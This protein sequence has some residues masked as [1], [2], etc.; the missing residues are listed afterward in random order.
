MYLLVFLRSSPGE[1][2]FH[3]LSIL[4]SVCGN[5]CHMIKSIAVKVVVALKGGKVKSW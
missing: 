5:I 1:W 4:Q 2:K 3:S